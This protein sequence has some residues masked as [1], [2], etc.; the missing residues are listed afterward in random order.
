M[1]QNQVEYVTKFKS[2]GYKHI[3][4]ICSYLQDIKIGELISKL[5]SRTNPSLNSPEESQKEY[6]SIKQVMQNIE[7]AHKTSLTG[8]EGKFICCL[9]LLSLSSHLN[10]SQRKEIETV[11]SD[12]LKQYEQLRL[13]SSDYEFKYYLVSAEL[14]KLKFSNSGP[15]N[16]AHGF[17]MI[18]CVQNYEN[19]IKSARNQGNCYVEA[20]ANEL[21]GNLW[22]ENKLEKYCMIHINEA[23]QLYKTWG[24]TLKAR[25]LEKQFYLDVSPSSSTFFNQLFYN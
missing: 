13:L 10:D 8:A 11:S 5:F 24:A 17:N 20:L 14:E 15:E 9:S 12:V 16:Q 1:I 25:N 4:A 6:E 23:V 18:K 21:L 19:A 3:Q 2:S 7:L 22:N